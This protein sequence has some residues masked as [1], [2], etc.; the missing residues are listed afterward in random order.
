MV[1]SFRLHLF[2]TALVA[3]VALALPRLASAEPVGLGHGIKLSLQKGGYTDFKSKIEDLGDAHEVALSS[4]RWEIDRW[5]ND[6]DDIRF[7]VF[8]KA[9]RLMA[10]SHPDVSEL[11]HFDPKHTHQLRG[12]GWH[13]G[14]RA[15]GVAAQP[16]DNSPAPEPA[17]MIL[18][19]TGLAGVVAGRSRK[20]TVKS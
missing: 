19:G 1:R 2:A 15:K 14:W 17:S 6:D 13:K 18:L 3:T 12:L 20:K 7:A 4:I 5:D 10:W 11:W 8:G 9:I 16:T